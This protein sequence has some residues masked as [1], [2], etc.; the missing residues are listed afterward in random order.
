MELPKAFQRAVDSFKKLPG[1][2]EKTAFR[3]CM[4]LTNWNEQELHEFGESIKT[5]S[6]IARCEDCGIFSTE[7]KCKICSSPERS[8]TR[9]LCIVE[10]VTDCIAIEQSGNFEGKF[11][12]VGGVLNPLLGVGP[13]DLRIDKLIE[14]INDENVKTV[15]LALNPTVE[16]DATSSYIKQ[17]LPQNIE[18]ERIGFGMPMGGSF[19]YLDSMTIG[20]ALENRKRM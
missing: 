1:V 16:G 4:I 19:E 20:K 10:N 8:Q 13:D 11:H 3:Q 7:K 17:L 9:L 6:N 5:L 18:V 15:I 12:I 2:G 14:R